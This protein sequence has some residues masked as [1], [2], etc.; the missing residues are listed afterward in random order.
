[1]NVVCSMKVDKIYIPK[2]SNTQAFPV[3]PSII[4]NVSMLTIQAGLVMLYN[5]LPGTSIFPV[6]QLE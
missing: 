5:S 4:T 6:S 1:M 2:N 3:Y